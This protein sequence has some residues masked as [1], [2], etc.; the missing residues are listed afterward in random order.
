MVTSRSCIDCANYR[1][2]DL[3]LIKRGVKDGD[4]SPISYCDDTLS[5]IFNPSESSIFR[6]V[7]FVQSDGVI[8]L[9]DFL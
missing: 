3:L 5:V 6:S 4:N 8:S 9:F 7:C 2:D 1:Y